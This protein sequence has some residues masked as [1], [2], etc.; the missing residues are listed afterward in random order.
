MA[1]EPLGLG[2]FGK[3]PFWP[4]YIDR[5][6]GLP[7]ALALRSWLHEGKETSASLA[8][9]DIACADV[10]IRS[11]LR[12]LLGLPG[13]KELLVGVVRA[14]KDGGGRNFPFS[15]FAQVPRRIY[16]LANLYAGSMN[17]YTRFSNDPA[18]L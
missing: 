13:S 17:T 18:F 14:S 12:L 1:E 9:E 6:V 3:L 10:P 5:S 11:R 2:C 4:E 7:T 8:D 15:V 16:I